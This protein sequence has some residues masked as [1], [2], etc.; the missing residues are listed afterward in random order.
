[1]LKLVLSGPV[2]QP[3][4]RPE[5]NRTQLMATGPSVAVAHG[6]ERLPVA[7]ASDSEICKT[8]QKPVINQLQPVFAPKLVIVFLQVE[9]TIFYHYK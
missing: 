6:F 7:V 8:D 5:P 2:M 4:K 9:Y 3:A 1:M